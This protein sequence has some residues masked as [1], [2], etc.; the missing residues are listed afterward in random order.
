MIGTSLDMNLTSS[1]KLGMISGPLIVKS[2]DETLI[3]ADVT[4]KATKDQFMLSLDVA[5]PEDPKIRSR[6]MID[7][8]AKRESGSEKISA[9]DTTKNFQEFA[10]ALS[11]LSPKETF[12]EVIPRN[13][14]T[15]PVMPTTPEIDIPQK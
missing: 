9:P 5:S 4:L 10:D 13:M 1:G 6:G 7:I 8:T 12:D 14:D 3:S 11:A 15:I 2:G